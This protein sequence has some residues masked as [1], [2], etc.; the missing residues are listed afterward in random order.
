MQTITETLKLGIAK[1][2]LSRDEAFGFFNARTDNELCAM[3]L[4][5]RSSAK[6]VKQ[7]YAAAKELFDIKA[8]GFS[9]FFLGARKG[10]DPEHCLLLAARHCASAVPVILDMARELHAQAVI[11]LDF[12]QGFIFQLNTHDKRVEKTCLDVAVRHQ[13]DAVEPILN[14]I[15]QLHANSFLSNEDLYYLIMQ[16]SA[17]A[18]RIHGCLLVASYDNPQAVMPIL[19]AV[20]VMFRR[21]VLSATDVFSLIIRIDFY[22]EKTV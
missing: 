12:L 22:R 11:S 20:E 5:A 4:A 9:S 16:H 10:A 8:L 15:L 21:K 14:V 1:G 3:Q 17:D 13:A 6:S 19:N 7:L 2:G 18:M